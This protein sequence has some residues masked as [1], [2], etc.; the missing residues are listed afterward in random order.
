MP[1]TRASCLAGLSQRIEPPVTP[2]TNENR[3]NLGW[4]V[5]QPAEM[6]RSRRKNRPLAVVIT[7]DHAGSTWDTWEDRR[8]GP[9]DTYPTCTEEAML[10][11]EELLG[12]R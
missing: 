3:G 7:P 5:R 4:E 8:H 11:W 2:K 1:V 10:R 6:P 9:A 12:Q